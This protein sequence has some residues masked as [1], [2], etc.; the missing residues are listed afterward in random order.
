MVV[1]VLISYSQSQNTPDIFVFLIDQ[2]AS[3]KKDQLFGR[4]QFELENFIRREVNLSNR[5]IILGFGDNV[6]YYYDDLIT[7]IEDKERIYFKIHE[8][9]FGDQWTHMSSAF[10]HIGSRLQELQKTYPESLKRIYIFTDGKNEP[11]PKLKERP[12]YFSEILNK[13]FSGKQIKTMNS[14]LYYISFGRETPP[15]ISALKKQNPDHVE[16]LDL[17]RS[18]PVAKPVIP[19]IQPKLAQKK[20]EEKKQIAIKLRLDKD[21]FE[22][23]KGK[24]KEIILPF[25]VLS[26]S[27]GAKL[28][29]ST[30]GAAHEIQL[31]RNAKQIEVPFSELDQAEGLHEGVVSGEILEQDGTVEPKEFAFSYTV[32]VPSYTIYY[33]L[34]ALVGVILLGITI[35][36]YL[37]SFKGELIS[38][39]NGQEEY[40][41]RLSGKLCTAI[42]PRLQ[43]PLSRICP[44]GKG[45]VK[46]KILP[47]S[48]ISKNGEE[49]RGPSVEMKSEDSLE[50][51][52]TKLIYFYNPNKRRT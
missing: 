1:N 35:Y 25:S 46:V 24:T 12:E 4:V 34:L 9:K 18:P 19:V 43:M 22:I 45:R 39:K 16:V 41:Q 27:S 23:R 3:M 6:S 52:D 11:D 5:V 21:K 48:I 42:A 38:Y 14:F 32:I 26:A 37:P 51:G 7:S 50:F 49:V 44:S 15:E 20:E 47:R 30:N 13:N 10:S 31:E 2:S 40:K 29:F 17:P 36:R 33:V 28:R 8:L